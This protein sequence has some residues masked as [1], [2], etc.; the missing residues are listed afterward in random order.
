MTLNF[1]WVLKMKTVQIFA[2]IS[3]NLTDAQWAEIWEIKAQWSKFCIT[4]I[5]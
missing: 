2:V 1:L 4:G 5:D 3:L